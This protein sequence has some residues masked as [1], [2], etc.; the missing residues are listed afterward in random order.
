MITKEVIIPE[1]KV[2]SII[3][4]YSVHSK[5][6]FLFSNLLTICRRAIE[7]QAISDFYCRTFYPTGVVKR[8]WSNRSLCNFKFPICYRYL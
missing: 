4:Y 8:A 5:A 3:L 2:W 7:I 6:L 1:D